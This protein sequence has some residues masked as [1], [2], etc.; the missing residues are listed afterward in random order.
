MTSVSFYFNVPDKTVL[1]AQLLQKALGQHRKATIFVENADM[2]SSL[3]AMLWQQTQPVFLAN[4]LASDALASVTPVVIDWQPHT[5]FQD[6]ILINYQPSQLTFFSRF[7][8][9]IE[10]VGMD[11][12]DKATAR[13][14][15]LFYR[16]RGYDIKHVDMLKKS[17]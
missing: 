15:F 6:D 8:Q 7:K 10:V 4:A 11:E 14:R 12:T 1:L 9:L 2:A 3:A 13:Q 17:I 5:V 16:D